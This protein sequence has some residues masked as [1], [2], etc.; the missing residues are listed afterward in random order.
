MSEPKY[1]EEQFQKALKDGI[2]AAMSEAAVAERIEE[3]EGQ[4]A[5]K[6]ARIEELENQNSSL[7]DERDG[8]NTKLE[9]DYILMTEVDEKIQ[10]AVAEALEAE[11][12]F[13]ARVSELSEAGISLNEASLE[14]LRDMSSE[15]YD[16]M[17]DLALQSKANDE[18]P[19]DDKNDDETV[20]DDEDNDDDGDTGD[21]G[22]ADASENKTEAKVNDDL[23]NGG[24]DDSDEDDPIKTVDR[25]LRQKIS[26]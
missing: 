15:D 21:D 13:N 9:S 25:L 20:E 18:D 14:K 12:T 24:S 16:F 11:R 6:D 3:L 23:P 8:I 7:A 5:D 17:K 4:L 19:E 1:T 26:A 2:K 22:E 10:T